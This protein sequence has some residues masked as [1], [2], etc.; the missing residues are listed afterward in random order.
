[1]V[2][3]GPRLRMQRIMVV[4]HRV[5]LRRPRVVSMLLPLLGK[6]VILSLEVGIQQ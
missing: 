2:L 6:E 4:G 5:L 3:E 1:M